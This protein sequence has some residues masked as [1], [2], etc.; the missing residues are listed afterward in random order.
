[1][2]PLPALNR[3]LTSLKPKFIDWQEKTYISLFH[4]SCIC[5]NLFLC[6]KTFVLVINCL[7]SRRRP[8]PIHSMS[9][10]A[11]RAVNK[12]YTILDCLGSLANSNVS[13]EHLGFF[14]I[15]QSVLLFKI[16]EMCVCDFSVAHFD[17]L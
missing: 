14:S 1:M 4:I 6:F 8:S 13:L 12:Q 9:F 7:F 17:A 10:Q 2:D 3:H 15:E 11:T 16:I 5:C